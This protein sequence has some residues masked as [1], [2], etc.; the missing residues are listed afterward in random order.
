MDDDEGEMTTCESCKMAIDS[1]LAMYCDGFCKLSF[2]SECVNIDNDAFCTINE[3]AEHVKWFCSTCKNKLEML[4]NKST[5]F[6]DTCDWPTILNVVLEQLEL[7]SQSNLDLSKRMDVLS[8]QYGKVSERLA[9]I[10][11]KYDA[12]VDSGSNIGLAR[13]LPTVASEET[14]P[15]SEEFVQD[16]SPNIGP[17]TSDKFSPSSDR[18]DSQVNSSS[19][20]SKP[21]PNNENVTRTFTNSRFD[22]RKTNQTKSDPKPYIKSQFNQ[23]RGSTKFQYD[24]PRPN[25]ETSPKS[26]QYRPT[27]NVNSHVQSGKTFSDVLKSNPR[28]KVVYGTRKVSDTASLKTVKKLFWLFLSGLDPEM[29]TNAVT[30][31]LKGLNDSQTYVCEKLDTR[32]SSYSSF[33]VGVPYEIGYDLMH[34][35]L[36]PQGCIVGKYRP[37]KK[38]FTSKSRDNEQHF[39]GQ[40]Q[41]VTS[42]A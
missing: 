30:T 10:S 42:L 31:Y 6:D 35:N 16:I 7:Q 22:N 38:H 21:K 25:L 20:T 12:L 36:W 13:P 24:K 8:D 33:K 41:S 14:E 34:P 23:S 37:P 11:F 29:D 32:F 40:N 9:D 2:H 27:T 17:N 28:S 15:R 3:L 5:K 39:L 18:K 19:L 4:F 26:T 1:N